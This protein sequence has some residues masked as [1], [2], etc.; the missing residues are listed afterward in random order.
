MKVHEQIQN[1]S[2]ENV[3]H[4][5][6]S[7]PDGLDLDEAADRLREVGR[8]S[9]EVKDPW[10]ILRSLMHQ[11]TNFFTLLLFASAGI[12]FVAEHL[13]AGQSMMVLGW[14][15]AGVALLNALFS[16]IQEYRAER[17]ME[18]LRQFL[19]PMVQV[20]RGGQTLSLLSEELVPGDLLLLKEGDRV[21]ADTRLVLA[22][23]LVVNNAPLTGESL[24]VS[25]TAE[26]VDCRLV[27]SNNIAFAGCLVLRGSGQAIVFAT[28]LRTEFGKL[29]H[30]SQ[31]LRRTSSPL[32]RQ[33]AHMVRTLT[34]IAVSLGFSFFLFGMLSGRSLWVN[35]VFMMGIIVANVPEGL[36]PTF[37][38]A[39]AMGS[40]R[41]ARRNVLVTSLSAVESL[42]AVQ[43]ICTD[44]TG[45]L[46]HNQLA[47]TQLVPAGFESAFRDQGER[48]FLLELA[49]CASQ[50]RETDAG[51]SGDPLDVAII[52]RL[53]TEAGSAE[54]IPLG[55]QRHFPFD[56][57][58]KRAAGLGTVEGQQVFAVKG[59]WEAIR[60][61]LTGIDSGDGMTLAVDQTALDRAERT[62]IELASSGFRVVAVAYRSIKVSSDTQLSQ[63]QLEKELVLAGFLGIEDPIR[64]EVPAALASCHAAGVKVILITGD[65]PDTAMNVATRCGLIDQNVSAEVVMTGDVLEALS[66]TALVEALTTGVRIF[67]RTSPA[68]KMKIV[69]AI[70]GMDQ[71]V[72]MTGDGVNDAP[73]LKA[74]DIGIA[75]GKS[76]TDVA[77]ASAQIILLD[78]NFASIVAGIEEGRTVFLNIR[79]FT[80]YVLVS[81][82]P[83]ILPYLIYILLP[84]PLALTIIQIL[85][86]DLGTDIIPSMALGQEPPDPESMRQPPRGQEFRLLSPGLVV[87][88]YLFLGLLEAI[89]SL[90][91]F[92][93]VLVDGGWQFGMELG[94]DDPLYRSATGIALATILL[95][96]I[97]NLIGRRFA[98]LSGLDLGI[99][100]N[101][102]M[103]AGI[104]IQIIFSWGL[105]YFPPLQK[106]LGTGPVAGSVYLFAWL[107]VPLIF[108][109]DY[110]RKRLFLRKSEH[111]DSPHCRSIP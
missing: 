45:T 29:A 81:N 32:E 58:K 101:R 66:E 61:M 92:F 8:N 79:K 23:D 62:M 103:M 94:A 90:G 28:G 99:F 15:L 100:R 1:L 26:P 37:T 93:Y 19:P 98:N 106:I 63:D 42:G 2:V 30:L 68:Q 44:K 86:I 110:L 102:L 67:A 16:F 43:V 80:N 3:Y 83:E 13:Q 69:M 76:G 4:A 91:L 27:E 17:A 105:L 72:A 85:A 33:I 70:K 82:G 34:L 9:V 6:G 53:V 109:A 74:A 38:L 49:L 77:R 88:S 5:L 12:C 57:D 107:G 51:Y 47:V 25:L 111:N 10:R 22:E 75:M 21:P 84:V 31:A 40:K 64:D 20:V 52:E 55:A 41:M 50:V 36:L 14:A 89:W 54:Q 56:V 108:T 48:R 96:Q 78:D 35:L 65:H 87:H 95:M 7:G 11:F 71:V 59:A 104:M 97:G 60:P 18:S 39:L 46:T 73:A 24:P